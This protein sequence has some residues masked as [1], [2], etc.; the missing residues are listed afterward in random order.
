MVRLQISVVFMIMFFILEFRGLSGI[1][2]ERGEALAMQ[3]ADELADLLEYSKATEAADAENLVRI[4][5]WNR[6]RL[7]Q[8][9]LRF[10]EVLDAV[11]ADQSDI[12]KV[13]RDRQQLTV[14]HRPKRACTIPGWCGSSGKRTGNGK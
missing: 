11:S 10:G 4:T 13:V 9:R 7:L 6:K 5:K 3:I 8:E 12:R 2:Y 1:P 14:K